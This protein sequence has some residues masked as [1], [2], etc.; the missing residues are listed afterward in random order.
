MEKS[1]VTLEILE[2][3]GEL[4]DPRREGLSNPRLT[5]L[6][7]KTIALMSIHVDALFQF[8]TE[9]FFDILEEELRARYPEIR[10]YRCKS[11]GSPSAVVNAD[12]KTLKEIA[13]RPTKNA[14]NGQ[15]TTSVVTESCHSRRFDHVFSN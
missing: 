13:A 15:S 11:F 4:N 10:F 9:L 6:N 14:R 12:A 2:P 3:K 7:G 8:G 1:P 5:D